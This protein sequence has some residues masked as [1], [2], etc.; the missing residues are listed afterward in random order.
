LLQKL[1]HFVGCVPC[2]PLIQLVSKIR[3]LIEVRHGFARAPAPLVNHLKSLVEAHG[4][5]E[6]W[7][8]HPFGGLDHTFLGRPAARHI[9]FQLQVVRHATRFICR[10]WGQ[11]RV[12]GQ[13]GHRVLGGV[14]GARRQWLARE[15]KQL[16]RI[17]DLV[18]QV[19]ES[20]GPVVIAA[21]LVDNRLIRSGRHRGGINLHFRHRG[22][23]LAG[24]LVEVAE[25]GASEVAGVDIALHQAGNLG[26]HLLAL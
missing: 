3:R 11:S 2:H 12:G 17:V 9:A 24:L 18:A 20:G 26:K 14:V 16:P 13:Q 25:R 23:G 21:R 6:S 22:R 4:V 19:L 7:R 10:R 15:S 1:R 5:R 8:F